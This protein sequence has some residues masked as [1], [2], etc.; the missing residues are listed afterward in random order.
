MKKQKVKIDKPPVLFDKTQRIIARI[1]KR[2]DGTFLSYW[3][4]VNGS[5][6]H[7]DVVGF[8]EILK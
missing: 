8:Y 4:S 2:I 6:C 1:E 7:D 5:V 3:H